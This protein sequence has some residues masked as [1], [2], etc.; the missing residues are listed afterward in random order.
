MINGHKRG[1]KAV[2][3]NTFYFPALLH[4]RDVAQYRAISA[5]RAASA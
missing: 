3:A 4:E 5:L 2:S 1:M